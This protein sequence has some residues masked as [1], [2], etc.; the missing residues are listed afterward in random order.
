ML[1]QANA[2]AQGAGGFRR[3][4]PAWSAENANHYSYQTWM[5]DLLAWSLVSTDLDESQQAGAIVLELSG[6]ARSLVRN[7]S[8]QELQNCG[9]VN[10]QPVGPVSYIVSHL[11]LRCVPLGENQG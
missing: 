3:R 7:L 10:G 4:P 8:M 2:Q 6:E 1:M 11:A 5:Q 9:M